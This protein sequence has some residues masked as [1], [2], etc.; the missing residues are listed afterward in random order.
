L[1]KR[2][3]VGRGRLCVAR[4]PRRQSAECGGRPALRLPRSPAN[5]DG[6]SSQRRYAERARFFARRYRLG[7]RVG[8]G[9]A[10]DE[11][12]RLQRTR[13]SY[14][15]KE[16]WTFSVSPSAMGPARRWQ[17]LGDSLGSGWRSAGGARPALP[18]DAPWKTIAA[19]ESSGILE[20]DPNLSAYVARGEARAPTS[21][22]PPLNCRL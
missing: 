6:P 8:H 1:Q 9:G 11:G 4:V 3:V 7:V 2:V 13:Y 18:R 22:L 5:R 21:V 17:S 14:F 12:R 16:K 15:Q 20:E 19:I 10:S